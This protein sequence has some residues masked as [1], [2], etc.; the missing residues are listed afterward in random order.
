MLGPKCQ[1]CVGWFCYQLQ[2]LSSPSPVPDGAPG[3]PRSRWE[4]WLLSACLTCPLCP[5]W[6]S[7]WS[8]SCSCGFEELCSPGSSRAQC[9]ESLVPPPCFTPVVARVHADTRAPITQQLAF[10][11]CAA[12]AWGACSERPATAPGEVWC[13]PSPAALWQLTAPRARNWCCQDALA[14]VASLPV[15]LCVLVAS[16]S[17]SFTPS[18]LFKVG[19]A[20]LIAAGN[21]H[22]FRLM[23]IV[24]SGLTSVITDK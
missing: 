9:G 13:R 14:P 4:L 6:S 11:R 19:Y 1:R 17:G 16:V 2:G 22:A 3:L 7:V 24:I 10:L 8:L 23:T 15:L 21:E 20:F 12:P 18:C 5:S